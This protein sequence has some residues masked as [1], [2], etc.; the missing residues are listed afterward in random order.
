[1]A[2]AYRC[3]GRVLQYTSER[4]TEITAFQTLHLELRGE[5]KP[6][7]TRITGPLDGDAMLGFAFIPLYPSKILLIGSR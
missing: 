5:N 4:R 7:E 1:M 3:P 6:A 2:S